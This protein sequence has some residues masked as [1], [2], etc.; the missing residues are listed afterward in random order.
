[1]TQTRQNFHCNFRAPDKEWFDV[2][3]QFKEKTKELGLDICFVAL[4]LCRAWLEW[5]KDTDSVFELS[6][7]KQI[8]FLSQSNTFNYN[9]QRPR[10]EPIQS[11][12]S[13]NYHK[14]TLCSKAF[15]AYI[16]INAL[17]MNRAFCFRDF[18]E[19]NHGLFRKLILFLKGE[20]R[21]LPM[22]PRSLPEFYI[23]SEW[24][25]RYSNMSENNRVKPKFTQGPDNI[26][27]ED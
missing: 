10:R 8:V 12:C 20:G 21:I 5:Q 23:L 3:L 19:I 2:W 26:N 13:K 18:P 24:K 15:C 4:N 6:P 25:N 9:V 14:C 1:M 27:K 17:E 11:N 22:K 16:I 7:P